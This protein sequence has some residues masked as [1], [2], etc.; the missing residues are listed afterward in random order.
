MPTSSKEREIAIGINDVARM[1][2]TYVDQKARQVGTTRA[3]WF[4]LSRIQ[5]TEGLKQSE[6]AELCDLQPISLC[7]LI[8]KLCDQGMIERR[9]D[10]HDR[11]AKRLFLKPA[12]EP[13]LSAMFAMGQDMME[14]V[15]AGV[16][17]AA[18]DQLLDTLLT[19]KTNLRGAIAN[20]VNEPA[21]EQAHG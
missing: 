1:L 11:R 21:M 5:R 9:S 2:R 15:L 3:Q 7:R 4:V 6:L 17:P 16:A 18:R 20:R 19:M 10:P 13:P 8:D 14:I 12:A